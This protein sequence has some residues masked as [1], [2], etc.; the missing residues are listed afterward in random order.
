MEKHHKYQ[1][2]LESRL[3]EQHFYFWFINL[4]FTTTNPRWNSLKVL[5][6]IVVIKVPRKVLCSFPAERIFCKSLEWWGALEEVMDLLDL[7]ETHSPTYLSWGKSNF[8]TSNAFGVKYGAFSMK[9]FL[10]FVSKNN[11][12]LNSCQKSTNIQCH[13]FASNYI[14]KCWWVDCPEPRYFTMV[15]EMRVPIQNQ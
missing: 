14:D 12:F 13:S 4:S 9:L 3:K 1:W 2:C 11:H 10:F 15:S 8:R 5:C 6:V 7:L